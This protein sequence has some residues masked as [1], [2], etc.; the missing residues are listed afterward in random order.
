[1]S[2]VTKSRGDAD[3]P[4]HGPLTPGGFT[5]C[6]GSKG[7]QIIS[8]PLVKYPISHRNGLPVLFKPVIIVNSLNP[9]NIIDP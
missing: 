8:V 4:G 7:Q 9:A 1:M 5:V 2:E 6:G 3:L